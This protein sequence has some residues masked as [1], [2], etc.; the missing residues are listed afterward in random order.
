MSHHTNVLPINVNQTPQDSHQPTHFDV[1]GHDVSSDGADINVRPADDNPS[2]PPPHEHFSGSGNS[3]SSL[4]GA[5]PHGNQPNDA[6]IVP[7]P[8]PLLD[9][10]DIAGL[11][12]GGHS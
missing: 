3:P 4:M 8:A 5:V 11:L 1:D 12:A 7:L 6:D 10:G 9:V 2:T